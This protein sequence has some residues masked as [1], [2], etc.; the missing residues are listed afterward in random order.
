MNCIEI[1]SIGACVR[2]KVEGTAGTMPTVNYIDLVGI[3]S[4]PAFEMTPQTIE[5][6][7]LGDPYTMYLPYKTDAGGDVQFTL[8]LSE[9]AIASWN[10][11]VSS[12]M[13]GWKSGKRTWFEY[14]YR[15]CSKSY[16]FCGIPLPLG[17]GGI[18][19]NS[20]VTLT[21]HVVPIGGI[22]WHDKSDHIIAYIGTDSKMYI[23]TDNKFYDG[24]ESHIYAPN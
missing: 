22:G 12:S 4:A 24:T 3:A 19:Q 2:Y 1:S 10:E 9:Q 5:I 17:N 15:G 7:N 13:T 8:N 16:F 11:L 21:A 23:G 20:L 14:A 6:S 18:E